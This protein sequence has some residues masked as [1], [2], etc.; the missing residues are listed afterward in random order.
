MTQRIDEIHEHRDEDGEWDEQADQIEVRPARTEIVSFRL[1]LDELDK[2]Q[3]LAAT[4]GESLSGFIRLALRLFGTPIGPSFE[5]SSGVHRLTVRSHI[6]S[7]GP[8]DAPGSF[9]PDFPP[10]K[11]VL[12]VGTSGHP[13]SSGTLGR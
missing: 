6:I 12:S 13:T 8:K 4:A 10:M 7:S 3:E 11:A 2:V 9:V 5:F 1:P